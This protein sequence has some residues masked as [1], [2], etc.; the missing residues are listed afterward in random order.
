MPGHFPPGSTNC[1]RLTGPGFLVLKEANYTIARM[2]Y[3]AGKMNTCSTK[4]Y[5]LSVI[6]LLRVIGF[7]KTSP[8]VSMLRSE[9][10]IYRIGIAM[11]YSTEIVT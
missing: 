3:K 10:F 2:S 11:L 7:T 9:H 1:A 5:R 8:Q 4:F 6:S